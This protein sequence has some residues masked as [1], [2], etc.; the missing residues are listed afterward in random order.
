VEAGEPLILPVNFA[1][2]GR[3]L[4]FRTGRG[5]KLAAA[6]MEQAVCL[7]V[8]AFDTLE[9]AGWSVLVRGIAEEV[10]D[11]AQ[12]EHFDT[13]PVMPWSRPDLRSHWVRIL[14]QEVSGRELAKHA[15]H[16]DGPG[17]SE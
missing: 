13:L 10:V 7:E 16:P 4:V 11:A 8:D 2:D 15:P 17:P 5:S 14:P 6:I 9:H 12:I 3:S 1:V